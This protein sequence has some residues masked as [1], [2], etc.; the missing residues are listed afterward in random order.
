MAELVFAT[1]TAEL[2]F[3]AVM[4]VLVFAVI[5]FAAAVRAGMLELTLTA[6]SAGVSDGS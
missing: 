2:V 6:A 4:A 1:V 3:A 5:P